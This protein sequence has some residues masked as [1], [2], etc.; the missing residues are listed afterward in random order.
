MGS[1]CVEVEQKL[2][3]QNWQKGEVFQAARYIP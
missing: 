1:E 2:M 3:A